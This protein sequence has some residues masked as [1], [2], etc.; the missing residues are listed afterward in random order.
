MGGRNNEP[1]RLKFQ[2]DKQSLEQTNKGIATVDKHIKELDSDLSKIGK[3]SRSAVSDLKNI[4]APTGGGVSGGGIGK[5]GS[6]AAALGRLSGSLNLGGLQ[7]GLAL[8]DDYADVLERAGTV[9]SK[10]VPALGQL[11]GN[12]TGAVAGVT[13]LSTSAAALA[14][15]V[16]L[17]TVAIVA[18]TIA[19]GEFQKEADKYKAMLQG[20]IDAEAVGIRARLTGTEDSIKAQIKELE[21]NREVARQ[22]L[23]VQQARLNYLKNEA[24]LLTKTVAFISGQQGVLEE[25]LKKSTEEFNNQN[26][27]ITELTK[28]LQDG[29]VKAR[30]NADEQKKVAEEQ[31][32]L[33]E[34]TNDVLKRNAEEAAKIEQD[35]AD[36]FVDIAKKFAQDS[37]DALTALERDLAEMST[38]QSDERM[39]TTLDAQREEEK[40]ARAHVRRLEDI[41]RSA[42][43]D[44]EDAIRNRDFA[45]LAEVRRGTNKQLDEASQQFADERKE[46][47]IALRQQLGDLAR[48]QQR[49]REARLTAYRNEL[50]D[51]RRQKQREEA[52]TRT[53]NQRALRDLQTRLLNEM[54]TLRSGYGQALGITKDFIDKFI[55][56]FQAAGEGLPP[57]TITPPP[58]GSTG[59]S[60][61]GGSGTQSGPPQRLA[62]GGDLAA[63]HSAVVNELS[64]EGFTSRGRTMSLPGGL[65]VFTP[66][67]SGRVNPGGGGVS[68][69]NQLNVSGSTWAELRRNMHRDLDSKLD[70]ALQAITG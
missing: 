62:G 11:A 6:G 28:A 66:M 59:G 58:G 34:Q 54:A 48:S 1:I 67:S 3:T 38:T 8:F 41:R 61:G 13:G 18:M 22:Q 31:T 19:I 4:K 69:T 70:E 12:M 30:T 33:A 27:A 25:N 45:R 60:G 55:K 56:Q 24:D 17:A 5:L 40:S 53:A 68:I 46:R 37:A 50:A 7:Q 26:A 39:Q 64:N 49:E 44:E 47:N 9:V 35:R 65:G 43:A 52:D 42:L 23:L 57:G 14:A 29:G 16:P 20:Q 32:K 51:L 2:V 63:R 36:K 15:A 10:S 21:V